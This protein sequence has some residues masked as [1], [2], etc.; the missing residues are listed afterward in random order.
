VMRWL[1]RILTFYLY[2]GTWVVLIL[3]LWITLSFLMGGGQ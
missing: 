1:D 2:V 3:A